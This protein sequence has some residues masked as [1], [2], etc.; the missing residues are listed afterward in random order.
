L[1]R[2]RRQIH[3]SLDALAPCP[4]HVLEIA[5]ALQFRAGNRQDVI[6]IGRPEGADFPA[7][8]ADIQF[9]GAAQTGLNGAGYNLL[10][11]RVGNEEC[12]DEAGARR[13]S[14]CEF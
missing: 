14:A 8:R 4:A 2:P 3:L 5:E 13:V 1:Q 12:G 10:Q 9:P 7:E 11:W 6:S